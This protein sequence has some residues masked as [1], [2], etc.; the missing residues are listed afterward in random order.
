MYEALKERHPTLA[1]SIRATDPY[2]P[3]DFLKR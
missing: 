1:A 3:V 2:G